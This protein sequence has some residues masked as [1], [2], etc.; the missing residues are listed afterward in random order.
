[1]PFEP[2][3]YAA[4]FLGG[5]PSASI[6][7]E[8]ALGQAAL[9]G[10]AKKRAAEYGA[11]LQA[12]RMEFAAEQAAAD[13]SNSLTGS[14][15]G[16]LGNIAGTALTA[17]IGQMQQNQSQQQGLN[18]KGVQNYMNDRTPD[19]GYS[20]TPTRSSGL[21]LGGIQNYMNDRTPGFTYGSS[22]FN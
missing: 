7:Q 19:F 22:Y 15:F 21:D 2:S 20:S 9:R 5:L 8:T 6:K 12:D 4:T 10:M 13:R 11:Q 1:M 18:L 17:G 14:I 3:K 16:A